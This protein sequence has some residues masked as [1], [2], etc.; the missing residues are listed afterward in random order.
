MNQFPEYEIM[1]RSTKEWSST[2]GGGDFAIVPTA[3]F[4]CDC[5]GASEASKVTAHR[6][7]GAVVGDVIDVREE[8]ALDKEVEEIT[9]NWSDVDLT[10]DVTQAI[11]RCGSSPAKLVPVTEL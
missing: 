8:E 2:L 6:M 7:L 1:Q 10:S 11:R 5:Y 3:W 9:R 4:S